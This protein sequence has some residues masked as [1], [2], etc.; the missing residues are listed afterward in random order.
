MS[1]ILIQHGLVVDTEPAPRAMPATDL[2]IEDGV[3]AAVGPGLPTAGAEVIDARDRVVLPGFVDTHRHTWQSVLRS[4]APYASL[5]EYLEAIVYGAT[6]RF[7]PEDVYA[8][9]LA[10]ALECLN[11]GIT[12]LLDWSHI[13]RSPDHTD[14]AVAALRDSGIRAVFGYAHPA[15]D[16]QR[17]DEVRRALG[18]VGGRVSM[19]LAAWGPGLATMEAA[20]AEW[21]L[22]RELGLRISVHVNGPGPIT[23][24]RDHGLLGA[25]TTYIHLNGVTDE[26]FTLIADTGGT[27]SVS[28]VLEDQMRLGRPEVGRLRAA[29]VR[30]TLGAD[31][32]TS[33]G[34]DMFGLMR[35]AFAAARADDPTVTAADVLRMATLDGAAALGLDDRIGSLRPGKQADLVLLRTDT[36]N[37]VPLRDPITAVVTAA[38][39]SNVDTVLVGGEIV[40]RD[41]RLVRADLRRAF[42]LAERSAAHL[43][44]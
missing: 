18:L 34:G 44:A 12:T 28:P 32:V 15:P 23:R 13:Q 25:D 10:G 3:I 27:A 20:E 14:A 19:T 40:K 7:R 1:R 31:A 38:D 21:R 11:S 17:P 22:A 8:G 24:L 43:A 16:A 9:D 29:G 26:E 35:A 33:V 30:T 41:G 36:P 6:P 5:G 42:D 2:L 39:L 4:T 37:L